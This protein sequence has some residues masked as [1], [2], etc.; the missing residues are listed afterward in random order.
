M[1]NISK[2]SMSCSFSEDFYI[3]GV[4]G[5]TYNHLKDIHR[6]LISDYENGFGLLWNFMSVVE[7]RHKFWGLIHQMDGYT[8]C[9]GFAFIN[10]N[11]KHIKLFSIDDKYR[12][13]GFGKR[14]ILSIINNISTDL[15]GYKLISAPESI[16]F[17]EKV[18]FTR[19]ND[20]DKMKFNI[21]VPYDEITIVRIKDT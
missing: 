4:T 2:I 5:L 10:E 8:R 11:T 14:F 15:E 21:K 19:V 16:P 3:I 1:A 7:D 20:L 9:I 6:W 17:W 18:G 12:K 13:R